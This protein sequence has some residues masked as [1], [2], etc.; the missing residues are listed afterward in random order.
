MLNMDGAMLRDIRPRLTTKEWYELRKLKYEVGCDSW[1][2]FFQLLLKH[3]RDV[4]RVLTSL[5]P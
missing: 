1:T 4:V 2:E 5:P 3:K